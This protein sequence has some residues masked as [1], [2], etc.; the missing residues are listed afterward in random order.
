MD[1]EDAATSGLGRYVNHSKLWNTHLVVL[2]R[3]GGQRAHGVLTVTERGEGGL[4]FLVNYG[5]DYWTMGGEEQS[6]LLRRLQIDYL[7]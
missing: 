3:R 7:P 2:I 4:E 1:A 6:S 5:D